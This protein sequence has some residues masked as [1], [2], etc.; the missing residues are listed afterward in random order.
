[1]IW[2]FENGNA[3]LIKNKLMASTYPGQGSA[4][5]VAANLPHR[6]AKAPLLTG[7][8]DLAS[9]GVMM[10]WNPPLGSHGLWKWGPLWQ[11]PNLHRKYMISSWGSKRNGFN[12]DQHTKTKTQPEGTAC[13]PCDFE[14]VWKSLALECIWKHTISVPGLPMSNSYITDFCF[15]SWFSWSAKP[16]LTSMLI[17]FTIISPL[18]IHNIIPT[19]HLFHQNLRNNKPSDASLPAW[20][21]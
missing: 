11:G 21:W 19:E 9:L 18:H 12:G 2:K 4:V 3:S 15:A 20:Q 1:M 8:S 6:T 5:K 7:P 16:Y 10:S 13:Q 17:H 14:N